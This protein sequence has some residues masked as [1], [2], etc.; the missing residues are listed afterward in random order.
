MLVDPEMAAQK[1]E[2]KGTWYALR[3]WIYGPLSVQ[4]AGSVL[5][6]QAAAFLPSLTLFQLDSS[7]GAVYT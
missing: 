5:S 3:E 4:R 2:A 1:R 6:I 7:A